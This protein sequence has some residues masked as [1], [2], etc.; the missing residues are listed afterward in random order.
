MW[1][2]EWVKSRIEERYPEIPVE[3]KIIHTSG[4]RFQ[5]IPLSRVGGKGLFVKEIEEDLLDEEIDLAVHSMKDV[6]SELPAGLH[7][8]YY[9]SQEDPRDAIVSRRG[10]KFRDLPAHGRVGTSSLRRQ[11]QLLGARHD[12][13]IIPIRGNVETRVQKLEE[14]QLDAVI[15]ASAGLKRLALGNLITEYLDPAVCLPAAGQ[16]VLGLELRQDD[17]RL[18]DILSFFEE[19]ETRLRMNAERSFLKTLEGGCQIPVGAFAE[20]REKQVA[21]SGVVASLDGKSIVR[22]SLCGPGEEA[23]RIGRELAERI[24][25]RGGR[26]I[27]EEV[28][29]R[30]Q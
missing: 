7:I 3:L 16:G 18:H 2:A 9:A 30:K 24:L 15:L 19:P 20:V 5:D 23:G 1:Q 11:A 21:L 12:L 17:R 6:P 8:G 22:D 10:E 27:L 28:Y 14:L 26:A 4:D 29:K 25:S 13:D